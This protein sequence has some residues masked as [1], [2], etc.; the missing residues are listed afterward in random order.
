MH[1]VV[2]LKVAIKNNTCDPVYKKGSYSLSGLW[3]LTNHNSNLF[4]EVIPLIC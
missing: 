4:A 1:V 3:S 2:E